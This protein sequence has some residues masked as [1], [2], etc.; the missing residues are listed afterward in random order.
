MSVPVVAVA[1]DG[2]TTNISPAR[3]PADALAVADVFIGPNATAAPEAPD[4]TSIE[5]A[6]AVVDPVTVDWLDNARLP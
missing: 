4:V 6:A 3:L 2:T 5:P 1:P